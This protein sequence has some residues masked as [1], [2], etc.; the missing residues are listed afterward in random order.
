M[1]I[2]PN[3]QGLKDLADFNIDAQFANQYGT[4]VF[5]Y[6]GEITP[7]YQQLCAAFSEVLDDLVNEITAIQVQLPVVEKH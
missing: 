7:Q 5:N 3:R 6:Q 4:Q 2:T 1:T